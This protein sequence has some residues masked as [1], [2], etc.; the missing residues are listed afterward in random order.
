MLSSPYPVPRD[1]VW[2]GILLLGWGAGVGAGVWALVRPPMSYDGVTVWLATLWGA[3]LLAGSTGVLAGHVLRRHRMELAGL[4]PALG[5]VVLYAAL[6]WQATLTDSP[7]T[8]TRAF[9]MVLLSCLIAA[10]IRWLR[11]V[12]KRVQAVDRIGGCD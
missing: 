12:E 9:L 10:R 2:A 6:S 1:P 8:G 7:G 5:G 3:L 4:W 11:G